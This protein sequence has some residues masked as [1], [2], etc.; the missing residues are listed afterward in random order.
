LGLFPKVV[1]AGGDEFHGKFIPAGT[2]ICMNTSSLLRSEALFG[3][4]TD[5]FTPERFVELDKEKRVEMERNVEL[6]FGYGQ[7]MC[8]G[9][10]VAF[11][12]LNK[13]IFEVRDVSLRL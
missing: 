2:A 3:A 6:A 5:V 1:P 10:T 12:E 4:D 13:T 11:M 7:W 8:V 9:K